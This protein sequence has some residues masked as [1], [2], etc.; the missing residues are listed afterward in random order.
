[1]SGKEKDGGCEKYQQLP[2]VIPS[3]REAEAGAGRDQGQPVAKPGSHL[4]SETLPLYRSPKGPGGGGREWAGFAPRSSTPSLDPPKGTNQTARS[5]EHHSEMG[6]CIPR[7]AWCLG[8]LQTRPLGL[9]VR[10]LEPMATGSFQ[11][12]PAGLPLEVPSKESPLPCG[13]KLP[14]SSWLSGPPF[15]GSHRT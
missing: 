15:L 3:A 7:A 14:Q 1:M 8:A 13:A 4:L 12:F 10:P 9:I 5:A 11:G 6:F 2:P